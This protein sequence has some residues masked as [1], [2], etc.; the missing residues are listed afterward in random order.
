ML[1]IAFIRANPSIFDKKQLSRGS[2]VSAA[3]ILELD[4]L[5]RSLKTEI[6]DLQ[7]KRNEIAKK[8]PKTDDLIATAKEVKNLI[9]SKN[10][11]LLDVEERFNNLMLS[12]PNMI[13]DDVPFGESDAD[14]VEVRLVGE[15]PQYNFKPLAHYELCEEQMGNMDFKTPSVLSGARFSVLYGKLARLERALVNFMLD[16]H[17]K[18][19]G[20]KEVSVPFLVK[21]L[22][23]YGTGQL[24]KFKEDLFETTDGMWLIPTA[25]VYLTN[26]SRD[27]I[28]R[29]GDLPLRFVA[30][31][32]CFRSEAGAAGRDTRG[33]VRQHQFTK[34]ELVSIVSPEKSEEEHERMT[35]A[36]ETV[37]QRL[38]LHYRVVNLCSKDIGFSA[39]KT[40]DI[41]VWVPGLDRYLEISSCSNCG[42]FQTRR[43]KTR[44]KRDEGNI[45]AHTL[46]GSGVAVGRLLVAIV[47]NY[48]TSD[49]K[50]LMPEVLKSYLPFEEI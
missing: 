41:E 42:D 15:K 31:T 24:P 8:M 23:L 18:E 43:M 44:I 49:G 27:K 40:Y 26:L 20:Y 39:R 50:I 21:D 34:V 9:A 11:E 47:E 16:I 48:Q 17:T 2:S 30:A 36:A 19:F 12:I 46:N 33:L 25:E 45:F 7:A 1:D 4:S 14:N 10:E 13:A 35:A 38:N 6:Q 22:A 5:V 32:S 3:D 29:D 28:L 37:L